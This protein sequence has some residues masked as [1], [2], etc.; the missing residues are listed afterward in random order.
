MKRIGIIGGL[1][2]ES[3]LYYYRTLIDLCH[4]DVRFKEDDISNYPE[5]I[6]YCVN[7]KEFY[8]L[9]LASEKKPTFGSPKGDHPG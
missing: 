2:N 4:E 7:I 1:S 9:F 8:P 3:T 6:I 5:I